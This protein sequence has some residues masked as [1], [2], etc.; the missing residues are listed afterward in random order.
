[1]RFVLKNRQIADEAPLQI[2]CTGLVFT[3][4]KTIIRREFESEL[5]N[6]I[7]QFPQLNEKWSAELQ[8]LEGHSESVQSVAFSPDGRLL[9]S[10]S[11]DKTVRL[12]DTATGILQQTLVLSLNGQ[13]VIICLSYSH[14]F[15]VDT[16]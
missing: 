12:W 2:Y 15:R 14:Q 6:W 7:C 8:T 9:V 4:R 5:P 11:E 13:R 3:P 10:G 16:N 1:M